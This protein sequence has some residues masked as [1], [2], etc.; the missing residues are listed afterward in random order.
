MAIDALYDIMINCRISCDDEY[1]EIPCIAIMQAQA[2]QA[3]LS[4]CVSR[5]SNVL[6]MNV[7]LAINCRFIKHKND[8]YV[9]SDG[10]N[11]KAFAFID[12]VNRT[13]CCIS[14]VYSLLTRM[15][16]L[17]FIYFIYLTPL[18]HRAHIRYR[19]KAKIK[20]S[21]TPRQSQRIKMPLTWHRNV[22]TQNNIQCRTN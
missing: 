3:H 6:D 19:V 2:T 7:R 1:S 12:P 14:T 17:L 4:S 20:S 21:R 22:N 18:E 9:Y 13:I 5:V 10:L 8:V 11:D 15:W 16:Y